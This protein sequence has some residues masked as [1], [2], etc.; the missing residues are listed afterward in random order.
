MPGPPFM[1]GAFRRRLGE[2]LEHRL[3]TGHLIE[4]G[5]RLIEL[6]IRSVRTHHGYYLGTNSNALP[7]LLARAWKNYWELASSYNPYFYV[8]IEVG[9]NRNCVIFYVGETY[10]SG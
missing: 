3:S 4:S 1:P 2:L 9:F 8:R 10:Y 7:G 6:F 5:A